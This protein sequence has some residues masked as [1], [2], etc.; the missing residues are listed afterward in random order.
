MN[1]KGCHLLL[2]VMSSEL[3]K[4]SDHI[5]VYERVFCW[6]TQS[7][8]SVQESHKSLFYVFYLSSKSAMLLALSRLL[9]KIAVNGLVIFLEKI[10]NPLMAGV[11]FPRFLAQTN[12]HIAYA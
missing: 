1:I 2:V 12:Q 10:A 4:R 6:I 7:S 8:H 3:F 5:E 11:K 9:H